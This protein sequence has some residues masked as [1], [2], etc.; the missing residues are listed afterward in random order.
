MKFKMNN[1]E[2]KIIE[3]N[4]QDLLAE[5]KRVYEDALYCFGMTKF[6][7]QMIFIN[8]SMNEEVKKQTLYH[9]LMHCYIW[10]HL[11]KDIELSEET[12]CDI[13]ANSHDIIHEIAEK[14]FK[15]DRN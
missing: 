7:D 9:E 5:Y 11:G 6:A 12:L 10:S 14:Y 1:R 8:A 13:S 2:W 15:I 3:V 4:A